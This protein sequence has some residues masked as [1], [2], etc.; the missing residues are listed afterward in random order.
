MIAVAQMGARQHYALP[1]ALE[2]LGLLGRFY[3][4]LWAGKGVLGLCRRLAGRLPL[5]WLRKGAGRYDA[6][7]PNGKV[8]AFTRFGLEYV[9]RLRAA[10]TPGQQTRIHLWA[11]ETFGRL[12]AQCGF[13]GAT[14]VYGIHGGAKTI[15]EAAGRRGLRTLLDLTSCPQ[16]YQVLESEERQRWPDWEA[17]AGQ[18]DCAAAAAEWENRETALAD[19]VVCPSEFV[20]AYARSRGVPDERIR[21]IPYGIPSEQFAGRSRSY[22]GDRPLRILF[23]GRVSRM[24]GAPYLLDALRRLNSRQIEARLIGPVAVAEK[25][26][27]PYR[28]YC[29]VLGPVPRSA[30]SR[31]YEWAD[32]FVFP[33]ICEGSALVTYEALSAW[34]PVI[35]TPNAGSAVRDGQDGFIVPIRDAEAIA[36][37][38]EMFLTQPDLVAACSQSA[39]RRAAEFSL[40]EYARRLAAVVP[41]TCRG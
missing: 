31:H 4:D 18:D 17:E 41:E 35:T 13:D 22:R 33:S 9:R 7:I 2:R 1:I 3:T 25:Q 11:G 14:A 30:V 12:I 20:R 10:R 5:A 32:V 19:A 34:L 21:V 28:G 15:F 37:R 36:E 29:D 8:T 6:R 16:L 40:D 39:S 24:K 23:V 27:A 26:L 38:I